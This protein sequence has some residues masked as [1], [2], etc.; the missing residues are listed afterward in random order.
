MQKFPC[1]WIEERAQLGAVHLIGI[2]ELMRT[3]IDTDSRPCKICRSILPGE[4]LCL[5]A[6][7]VFPRTYGKLERLS[8]ELRGGVDR[9]ARR[10]TE[11]GG[12]PSVHIGGDGKTTELS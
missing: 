11:D 2:F 7:D 4:A 10:T 12:K 9:I 1:A 3:G 8:R 6:Q 5:N